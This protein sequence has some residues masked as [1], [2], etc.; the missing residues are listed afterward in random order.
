MTRRE[1][2]QEQYEEAL[3]ALLM[4]KLAEAEGEKALLKNE[5]L[6]NDPQA[7][8]P[9]DVERRCLRTIRRSF[10]AQT[11]RAVGRVTGRL[12]SRV[13]VVALIGMLLVS[14]A[15]AA[16]PSFRINTMNFLIRTFDEYTDFGAAPV[17]TQSLPE[18]TAAWLPEGYE[19]AAQEESGVDITHYYRT[20]DKREIRISVYNISGGGHGVDTEDAE[21]ETIIINGHEGRTIFKEG[22]DGYGE[23]YEESRIVWLDTA[24]NW[25]IDVTSY[26]E[27]VDSLMQVAENLILE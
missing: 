13:A 10:S 5:E 18:I 11:V 7:A 2:L 19:L 22:Y 21:M 23:P 26:Q 9:E 17:K 25:C 8:L 14:A 1:Q 4:D 27:S 16:S 24:H 3:F 6:K 20:A 12:F 15:F